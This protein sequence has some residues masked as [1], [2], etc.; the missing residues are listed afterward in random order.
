M[1]PGHATLFIVQVDWGFGSKC[2]QLLL[3]VLLWELCPAQLRRDYIT[4]YE[5]LKDATEYE[6]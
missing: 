2:F 1:E 3:K 6:I 5:F 4:I